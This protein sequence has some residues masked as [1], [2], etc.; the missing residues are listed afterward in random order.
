MRRVCFQVL[1]TVKNAALVIFCVVFL[2]EQVAALQGL[3]YTVALAGFTWYQLVK[4]A[5]P[6]AKEGP[7]S[8]PELRGLE[9]DKLQLVQGKGQPGSV[10]ALDRL[11][12]MVG[13][14]DQMRGKV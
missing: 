3:G 4:M 1:G 13:S 7:H 14:S 2:G 12:E 5:K 9:T 10:N 11:I 6:P 8:R